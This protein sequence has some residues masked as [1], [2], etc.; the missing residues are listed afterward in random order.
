MDAVSR[1][2]QLCHHARQAMLKQLVLPDK[3]ALVLLTLGFLQH[4]VVNLEVSCLVFLSDKLEGRSQ[5]GHWNQELD[6]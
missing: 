1:S 6:L 3:N 5:N 2:G 4:G